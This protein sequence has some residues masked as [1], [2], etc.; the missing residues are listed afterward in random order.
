MSNN[1]SIS[2]WAA[3]VS[4]TD[5]KLNF[6]NEIMHYFFLFVYIL[7]IQLASTIYIP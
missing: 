5:N 6:W 4:F 3:R 1:C 2:I 7:K